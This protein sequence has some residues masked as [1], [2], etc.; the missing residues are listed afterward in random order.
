MSVEC[1]LEKLNGKN[2]TTWKVVITSLLKSKKLW[3]YCAAE[4]KPEEEDDMLKNE[5]AKHYMYMAMEPAQITATGSCETAYALWTKIKENHE[6]AE[7]DVQNNALA[8]FLGFKYRRNES[9]IQYC[10]RFE[11][12]LGR[13]LSTGQ[14]VDN[15][16]KIWVLRN[17][18]PKDAKTIVNTWG[19]ANPSGTVSELIT[20]LKI[21]FHTDRLDS[22][23]ES[24]ALFT[25]EA[26][27]NKRPQQQSTDKIQCN[28]CKKIGH[29]WRECRKLKADNDRKKK[30]A[31]NRKKSD[32]QVASAFMAKEKINCK[33]RSGNQRWIVDSG[34]SSHMTPIRTI[35]QDYIKFD[36]PREIMLGDGKL[37]QA[38][39]QGNVPFYDDEFR[40]E[41][42]SVLWV[43]ELT[44]NLFSVGRAMKQGCEVRFVNDP[45][46]VHFIKGENIKLRGRRGSKSLF[47]LNLTPYKTERD[48]AF[49]GVGMD[50][51]H[52]RFAH[53]SSDA[54]KQLLAKNAVI[55]LEV[56]SKSK[57]RCE[58]CLM[59]KICR[60]NHP[61]KS[62]INGTDDAAVLCIDTVGPIATESL[63]NCKYFV[64]A[65]E[66]FSNFKLIEFVRLKSEVPTVVKQIINRTE[67]QSK[68]PVKMIITDNG[69]EYVN[70]D[71]SSWLAK[72]GIVHN[73]AAQYTPEQNGRAERANRTVIEGTRTLLQSCKFTDSHTRDKLWAEAA[74]TVTYTS[75]FLLSPRN[76]EKTRYELFTGKKPD[77]SHLRAF[78][79]RAIAR[80]PDNQRSGKYSSKGEECFFLG[81]TERR[82]TYRLYTRNTVDPVLVTCDVIFLPTDKETTANS[83]H[84]STEEVIIDLN[85]PSTDSN[86][87]G[88]S[89]SDADTEICDGY[90][91]AQSI[92]FTEQERTIDALVDESTELYNEGQSLISQAE[93]ALN[94]VSDN[95]EEDAHEIVQSGPV[96][97]AKTR[98]QTGHSSAVG[99]SA[100]EVALFTLDDEPRTLKDA[101]ESDDWPKWKAAMDEELDALNKNKTWELVDKPAHARPIKCK[102][103]YKVKLGP[104]GNVERYK[105]RLVAK[106]YSQIENV[107]Y[108]ETFAPVASM[109]TI[110]I[111]FA[112]ANQ[113]DMD[114]VNFDVKTAFL[115][116]DLEETIYLEH[117][118]G[119][120]NPNNR[121]C[122]LIKSLYGLKQAPRQWNAKFDSFLQKFNLRQSNIDKCLYYN[123]SRSLLL[124]IYV[125]DGLAAARDKKLLSDLILYLKSNFELKV[126][127][128]ETYL[129]FQIIRNRQEK[130]LS[131]T[132]AHYID[133]ILTRFKMSDCK[134]ISTPEE[135]GPPK[136]DDDKQLSDECP[137]KELVGS[138]LYLVT[139][140]RPDI[141]HAVSMAS[142]TGTPTTTHWKMLKR[143][144]RYLKGSRDVGI[145]FRWEKFPELV[146]YCDADYANDVET[147]RSTSGYCIKYA[148]GP[149]SWR[150]QR[151]PIV[152]LSTT[153]AEYVSGCELT[154]ELIP[155][156]ELMLELKQIPPAPTKVMIDNQST[157]KIAKNENG[158]LRTKHIDVRDKWLT[159]QVAK[160][161]ITVNHVSGDK[162]AADLLTKPLHKTKF[163]T[164]RAMLLT[165]LTTLMM[166]CSV[167]CVRQLP[168]ANP[169]YFKPTQ[170][171]FF[172]GDI[173]FKLK[174]VFMNPCETYFNYTSTSAWRNEM[175]TKEC[176]LSFEKK[177]INSL[178]SCKRLETIGRNLTD[179]PV[180]VGCDLGG[181]PAGHHRVNSIT[182][183]RTKR[184]APAIAIAGILVVSGL[185]TAGI[186]V[187]KNN[188]DNINIMA[189]AMKKERE[190]LNN[191]ANLFNEFRKNIQSISQWNSEID[192]QIKRV[193]IYGELRTQIAALINN[194]EAYFNEFKPHLKDINKGFESGRVPASL[195]QLS[196][197]TLWDEPAAAWSTFYN[198]EYQL[199]NNSLTV[200]LHFNMP[201]RNPQIKIMEAVSMNFFNATKDSLGNP[202]VCWMKYRGPKHV[203]VNTTNNCMTEVVEWATDGESVRAQYCASK[204][205]EIK[206][207]GSLWEPETC[208]PVPHSSKRIIQDKEVNGLHRIYCYLYNITI[209]GEHMPCP[210]HVFELEGRTTYRIANMEHSGSYVDRTVIKTADLH[211][212][213]E[214]L[215][216]LKAQDLKIRVLNTTD[217]EVAYTAYIDKLKTIPDK[218]NITNPTLKSLITEPINAIA[219]YSNTLMNYVKTMGTVLGII[220]AL[221]IL[222]LI[223]PLVEAGMI[224]FKLLKAPIN[225]WIN[226]IKRVSAKLYP[227]NLKINRKKKYWDELQKLV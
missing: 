207:D 141:A 135:V 56:N 114:I 156:R 130:T 172:D 166:V 149:I 152:T 219:G 151:Q 217:M 180:T 212:N 49:V 7:K 48:R 98:E 68:R 131:L 59:G 150:C 79:Q 13:V 91:S 153:E 51:W 161:T 94:N 100:S 54:I 60:A 39:G 206:S 24:I 95:D 61:S 159:E 194:Y 154:K 202:S 187:A 4:I 62:D 182:N 42:Q 107:D 208:T 97:R 19:M 1:K 12:A 216:V 191:G 145:H 125:D 169:I 108:K 173:E 16:T 6:G 11:V 81:Y 225:M 178:S 140:T 176:N 116:G 43:P 67:L 82:N 23:E 46:E 110:R 37:T 175:L 5:E 29:K 167:L 139:C 117:P 174:T 196:N 189:E 72:R 177:L 101:Q 71:L 124:A 222:T 203:L 87:D 218:L 119:Y 121:V 142:R 210:D 10:G 27:T 146:G 96:T 137:F 195:R 55:G 63:G 198:C 2:Y 34:A 158:Q 136:Q 89:I 109:T 66:E 213:K 127:D 17:S 214:I 102:W 199:V 58:D 75:N 80:I 78:G 144:L 93:N 128:C 83:G 18:L 190:L 90:T 99:S 120:P 74:H 160:K 186:V 50:E 21:Q 192:A 85:T 197:E 170:Y 52:K 73:T 223:M 118:D 163:L 36:E 33:G 64:L 221:L 15:S 53:M 148:N 155:I 211:L 201:K 179:I 162:Q 104:N 8:D 76:K 112:V 38:Y 126:M 226:S 220:V 138:L 134:P 171:Q 92:S 44:E 185:S 25:G 224:I 147:R 32:S 40:G 106:G 181:C 143:I 115:Y 133:K 184:L 70:R 209:E 129:G 41:L 22:N 28:Y 205:D 215:A 35:I 30:F 157:I 168:R 165:P 31:T 77:V 84:E 20:Q 183:N 88:T 47:V 200:N 132:Q 45:P 111:L 188:A 123:D 65:T 227:N 204:E 122:K 113:H 103:V 69:T 14:T 105:A 57:P 3:Q 164:N 86:Q 9:I 26:T 193:E